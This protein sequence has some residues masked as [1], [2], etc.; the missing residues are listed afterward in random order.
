MPFSTVLAVGTHPQVFEPL[1]G[2][3][4]LHSSKE[5]FTFHRPTAAVSPAGRTHP[6]IGAPRCALLDE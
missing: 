1:Y 4:A 5:G 6:D 2:T 3:S